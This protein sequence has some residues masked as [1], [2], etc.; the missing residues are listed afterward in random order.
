LKTKRLIL[1]SLFALG[2]ILLSACSGAAFS[3]NWPGLAADEERAY[4]TSGT[5]VYAVDVQT[6]RQLWRFPADA[7][8]KLLFY[9]NPVLTEDGQLLIGSAGQNHTFFSI[10]PTSGRENWSKQ[11]GARGGWMAPPLVFND[12]IYAPN[13]D[14]FLYMF[15]LRGNEIGSPWEL[16]GALWSQP[17]TDGTSIYVTSLDHHLHIIDPAT[18]RSLPPINLGGA[19]PGSPAIGDGGVYVGSFASNI[20]F[21]KPSGASQVITSTDNWVWGTPVLDDETLFYADLEGIIYSLD[22]STGR[23]NWDKQKPDGPVVANPIIWEDQIF[24]AAESGS[25]IAMDRSGKVIWERTTGGKIYTTPVVSGG[26]ILVAPY[27][28]DFALAAYDSAGRQAWTFT[29]GK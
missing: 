9:A 20:K 25:F 12:V 14:G 6:G 29:P 4:I 26:L 22:L 10:D 17:V 15:D 19:A 21:V 11:N 24:F 23:Q 7:D 8:N 16:G 28:A 1:I 3:N 18:R 27:Q 5:Y 13:T 2:A